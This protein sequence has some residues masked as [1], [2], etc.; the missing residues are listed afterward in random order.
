MNFIGRSVTGLLPKLLGKTSIGC[1]F[2]VRVASILK[3]GFYWTP[4]VHVH[5]FC[6]PFSHEVGLLWHSISLLLQPGYTSFTL[7]YPDQLEVFF[8]SNDRLCTS[9]I[10][11][12]G[13]CSQIAK[14]VPCYFSPPQGAI[15]V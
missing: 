12:S 11:R 10:E 7:V 14:C 4:Q 13:I 5:L 15:Q 6:T 1:S 2:L 3:V 9:N 8:L